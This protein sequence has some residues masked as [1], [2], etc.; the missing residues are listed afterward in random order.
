MKI[1]FE[2]TPEEVR[3]Q[4]AEFFGELARM[5]IELFLTVLYVVEEN[6]KES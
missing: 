5:E 4:V 6:K 2:G 1:S 3:S